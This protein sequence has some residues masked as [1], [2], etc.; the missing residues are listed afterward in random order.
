MSFEVCLTSCPLANSQVLS[1]IHANFITADATSHWLMG[2]ALIAVSLKSMQV[3]DLKPFIC[4]ITF[5][6]DVNLSRQ[7]FLMCNG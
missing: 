5:L 4:N 7:P 3:W 6:S 2:V 1:V